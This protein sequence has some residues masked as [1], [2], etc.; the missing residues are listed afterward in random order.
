LQPDGD[1]EE[2]IPFDLDGN[3]D[4]DLA[5]AA[6]LSAHYATTAGAVYTDGD[7]DRDGDVDLSGLSA[8]LT[9]YGVACGS[10]DYAPRHRGSARQQANAAMNICA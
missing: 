9:V 1:T 6:Q 10:W 7:V 5:D 2:P 8:L 3:A 4:V